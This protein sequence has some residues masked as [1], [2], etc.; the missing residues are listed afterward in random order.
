M[1]K[2]RLG[3][4]IV[5]Y[6]MPVALIGTKIEGKVNFM[7]AAWMSMVSHTPPK[8]AISMGPHYTKK[9]IKE[10]GAF[11]VC[12][13]S[14]QHAELVDY[15]G[16]VSGE[17]ADKSQV[18]QC[19]YGDS[20][21]APMVEDFLL[22]VEC[23]LEKSEMNGQNETFIGEI[24]DLYAEEAVLTKGKVDFAKLDPILLGQMTMEYRK[25]GERI[26]QAW[27]MGLKRK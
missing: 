21:N 9:G 17:K 7:T 8:I 26:G 4:G 10:N 3:K 12:F 15:C 13:P 5:S 1:S 16:L 19:F 11:S 6:P 2:I 22:I 25:L 27:N 14:S 20:E 23:R 24:V 18:F